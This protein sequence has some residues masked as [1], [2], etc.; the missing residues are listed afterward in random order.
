MACMSLAYELGRIQHLVWIMRYDLKLSV[1]TRLH[2]S[3]EYGNIS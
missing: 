2:T 3:Y 1:D